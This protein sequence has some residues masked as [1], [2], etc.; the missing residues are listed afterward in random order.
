M[1]FG[2]PKGFENIVQLSGRSYILV[3]AFKSSGFLT[4][5]PFP[6]CNLLLFFLRKVAWGQI[7]S[8]T[9]NGLTAI[10]TSCFSSP[11]ILAYWNRSV[12][13]ATCF[14]FQPNFQPKKRNWKS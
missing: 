6:L 3:I 11:P 12:E 4:S 8:I 7:I 10:L 9:V 5:D 13:N 14:K 2:N 1:Y